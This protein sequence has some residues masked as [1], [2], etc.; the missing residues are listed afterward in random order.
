ME[1][2]E[3][4]RRPLSCIKMRIT[5]LQFVKLYLY[6]FH[7]RLSTLNYE[8]YNKVQLHRLICSQ[9]R[10]RQRDTWYVNKY[11]LFLYLR[12]ESVIIM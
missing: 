8:A 10:H 2:K 12:A 3:A 7:K 5:D 6:R 9:P 1:E 11:G 4:M